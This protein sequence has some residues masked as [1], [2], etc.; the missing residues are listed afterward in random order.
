[1]DNLDTSKTADSGRINLSGPWE[2]DHGTYELG[3]SH[4]ELI[5]IIGKVGNSLAAAR[6]ELGL[7]GCSVPQ[8]ITAPSVQRSR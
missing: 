2:A 7:A 4:G 3:V 5:N 6:K 8:V 1:M